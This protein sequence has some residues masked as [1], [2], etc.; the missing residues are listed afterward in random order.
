MNRRIKIFAGI[1]ILLQLIGCSKTSKLPYYD[2]PDFTPLWLTHDNTEKI[3]KVGDFAFTDQSG[4]TVNNST[5]ENKIYVANFF[6]TACQ[7]IC[8]KMMQN[9]MK[10]QKTFEK[11]ADVE[12]ASYSVMPWTDSVKRLSDYAKQMQIDNKKW[13]LMTGQKSRIYEL[14]RKSYFAEED[15]GYSLDSTNFLHTEHI[16]LVDKERH[17]RGVYNGTLPLEIDRLI[18]EKKILKMEG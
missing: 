17:L 8:P 3:H 16:L 14:A 1:I 4:M 10:V 13:H 5:F 9:V 12:L 15:M 18:E 6:F 11:D 7:S 2:T